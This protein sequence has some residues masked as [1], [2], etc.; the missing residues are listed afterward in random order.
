MGERHVW[1]WANEKRGMRS[2][3]QNPLSPKTQTLGGCETRCVLCC[4]SFSL[5]FFSLSPSSLSLSLSFS[6]SVSLL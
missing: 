2:R 5:Y 1:R 3:N 6:L 4:V